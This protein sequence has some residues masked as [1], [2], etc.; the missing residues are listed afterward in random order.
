MPKDPSAQSYR[1]LLDDATQILYDGSSTPRID[2]EVLLQAVTDRPLSWVIAYAETLAT[3]EHTRAFFDLVEK[4][5][6]G[7]PIAYLLNYKDFWTLRLKVNT[8]VLI[9]RSDTE[10]LIEHALQKLPADALSHVLDLG[11]GSGAIA[12]SIAKERPNAQV[13]ATDY[14]AKALEVA[15]NNAA[16]NE[17]RNVQ[18]LHSDWFSSIA[19][20]KK[21]DL[22][23]SNPP[24]VAIG[25]PH[26]AQGDLRFEPDSAL[27]SGGDG[28][29][30]L[31]KVIQ[32]SVNH[33]LPSAWLIVEHG[34]NQAR[35]VAQLFSSA[36]YINIELC[37]DINDLPRCTIGQYP[38]NSNSIAT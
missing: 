9:P 28:L 29:H 8:H 23:A 22:I 17:V 13:L 10:T 37:K 24:Y 12:L 3:A 1:Q 16:Y 31:E 38:A 4:R 21:F 19:V 15:K 25:D 35:E 36:G 26:L 33:L 11:T 34:Y 2:S 5:Q 32:G 27:I 7:Q 6:Q 30:D 14:Q 18:F 20:D